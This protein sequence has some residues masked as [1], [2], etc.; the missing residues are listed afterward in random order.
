MLVLLLYYKYQLS[1]WTTLSQDCA[2]T[3]LLVNTKYKMPKS[4]V[5]AL[6]I[7]QLMQT[8]A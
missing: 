2:I 1:M 8:D 4:Y 6:N 3:V 7:R 5:F